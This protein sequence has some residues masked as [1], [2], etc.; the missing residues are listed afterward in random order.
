M[1]ALPE[2]Y[3]FTVN[4]YH[5]MGETGILAKD[6]RLELIEGEIIKMA[7]IGM[8]HGSIVDRLNH[9]LVLQA[10]TGALQHAIVRVQGSIVLS[11]HSEPQPDVVLLKPRADFYAAQRPMAS[12]V[13][14]IIEVS[15]STLAD[16]RNVKIPLYARA[17]IP[18][19]WLIDLQG[20]AIEIYADPQGRTY[21]HSDRAVS[22]TIMPAAAPQIKIDLA[23]IFP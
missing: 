23:A 9:M 6:S 14:L 20:K 19:V 15:D 17:G 10:G 22:G 18:E 8:R 4:D 12:D 7:P 5:R 13:L 16:D 11:A 3:R 1:S 2:R 21:R